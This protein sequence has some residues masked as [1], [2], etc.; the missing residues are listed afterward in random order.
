MPPKLVRASPRVRRVFLQLLLDGKDAEA[1]QY[2]DAAPASVSESIVSGAGGKPKVSVI[3]AVHNAEETLRRCIDSVLNQ[4]LRDLELICVND[5][6]PDGSQAIID[7]YARR[8]KRVVSIINKKNIGHGATRNRGISVARGQYI[9]H[10]DPDD[11]LPS[12]A[13]KKI[14]DL[15][16]RYGSDMTRGAYWHEQFLLG[17]SNNRKERKGLKEGAPHT[18]NTTLKQSPN[19]LNHTEGHWSYLYR[20]DFA[21]QVKYPEDLKMGQD[22]IFIVN[23]MTQ[24]RSI[25]ITDALVYHYRAN[26]NSAMNTFNFRKFLDALEWRVRAWTALRGIDLTTV[27][28]HLLFRYWNA[29]FFQSLVERLTPKERSAFDEKLGQALRRAGYP[30]KNPPR[31]PEVAD[32]FRVILKEVAP[33]KVGAPSGP[34]PLRIATFST[35]DHGGAGIGSQRRVEALRGVGIDA[36]IHCVLKKTNKSYVHQLPIKK[37]LSRDLDLKTLRKI[38]YGAVVLTDK[39]HSSLKDRELFSKPVSIVNFRDLGPVFDEADIVHL[40]WVSGLFDYHHADILSDKPVAWT[41][42]DMNAFTGGC[43]YSEGCTNYRNECRDCPL[44]KPGSTLAHEAWEQ[45]RDAYSKIKNLHIICPSQW[46]AD[47]ARESSLLGDREIEVITNAM[48][49]G[50]FRPTNKLVARRRLGLPLDKRLI[51]FGAD[52]LG[53]RRKGGD[54]L[55]ISLK[56]LIANGQAKDVEGLFFGAANLKVG[57]PTHNMGYIADPE[58]LSLI[59]AAAD[60]FAFPSREDNAPLTVPEALLSATPVV[61]FPVGNVP[62]L[63]AHLDTGFIARYEDADHFAE[64]LAWA[65]DAPRSGETLM[66]GLR[67]HIAA[68]AYHDPQNTVDRYVALFRQMLGAKD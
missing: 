35:L 24:A 48:P 37:S 26:T 40:H 12:G 32:Y 30:G 36:H 63:V 38:W 67:G 25:S 45:K 55:A 64:G 58:K 20:A 5:Q 3:L 57:V 1:A 16:Q 46:L 60:V 11:T 28:E 49:V 65:L 54:I 51:V 9:F 42:A 23:A 31:D 4:S 52:N 29:A 8:D 22:S 61:A 62:E 18:V 19:L 44:L 13:L 21:K 66:R 68:R 33:V 6:T 56:K 17:E 50:H 2:I 39:E 59:Y 15:A 53:N 43:H 10:L 34:P 14:Y 47:C 7:D 41:L 27:G